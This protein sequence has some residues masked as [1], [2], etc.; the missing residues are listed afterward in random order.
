MLK[1]TLFLFNHFTYR[2]QFF[3]TTVS[4]RNWRKLSL[5]CFNAWW[6]FVPHKYFDRLRIFCL[7]L[8][9]S[10]VNSMY[11]RNWTNSTRSSTPIS[12]NFK[13]FSIRN[14]VLSEF[15]A[16]LYNTRKYQTRHKGF[17]FFFCGVQLSTNY[18]DPQNTRS[19]IFLPLIN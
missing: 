1:S 3:T 13:R 11:A 17:S 18:H 4:T 9:I 7:H 2:R 6:I 8:W 14:F 10:S 12:T 19:N 15:N 16:D 5:S